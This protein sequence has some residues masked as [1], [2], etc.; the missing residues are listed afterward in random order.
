[1][2]YSNERPSYVSY[3]IVLCAGSLRPRP[4]P[5]P[6]NRPPHCHGTSRRFFTRAPPPGP[7]FLAQSATRIFML[8]CLHYFCG[9]ECSIWYYIL[10]G[11]KLHEFLIMPQVGI[12]WQR[13]AIEFEEGANR[14]HD[15]RGV[16][17]SLGRLGC[18]LIIILP[19]AARYDNPCRV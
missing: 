5:R 15:Q 9:G 17:H 18:H 2:Q 10:R 12:L 14:W 13:G 7:L 11:R 4:R 6:K 3:R 16:N 1:M 19:I 8:A